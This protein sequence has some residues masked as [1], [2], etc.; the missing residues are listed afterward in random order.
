MVAF[1]RA[2]SALGVDKWRSL[3]IISHN[4]RTIDFDQLGSNKLAAQNAVPQIAES[5]GVAPVVF[6][7]WKL[8]RLRNGT[9]F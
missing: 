3:E 9:E 7:G 8:D 1:L 5:D 2:M 4:K 6:L